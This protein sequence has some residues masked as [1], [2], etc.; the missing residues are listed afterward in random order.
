MVDLDPLFNPETIAF[1]GASENSGYFTSVLQNIRETGGD[2]RT[3]FVNPNR[4]SVLG[5]DC[6]DAVHDV[7]EQIDLAYLLVPAEIVPA[8]FQ[9]CCEAS[10]GACVIASAGFAE[11]SA[12]GSELQDTLVELSTTYSVPFCGPNTFGLVSTDGFPGLVIP[13]PD[14]PE[15]TVACVTQSGGLL[16][17][18]LYCG[19][20][21]DFGFAKVVDSGNQASLSEADYIEHFLNDDRTELVVGLIESF[22][23][24]ERFLEL[25]A[26]ARSRNI[27]VVVHKLARSD[28]AKPIARSHSGSNPSPFDE[29]SAALERHGV[30]QTAS[31]DE[32][33]ETIELFTSATAELTNETVALIEIS[34]G[35]C[36]SYVDAIAESQLELAEFSDELNAELRQYIPD[37]IGR[38]GN[39]IDLGGI[40]GW[41][42]EVMADIYPSILELLD[43]RSEAG[44][45]VAR[46]NPPESGGG[47]GKI[48]RVEETALRA[49][50]SEKQFV[51][52]S[53]TSRCAS[54]EWIEAVHSRGLPFVQGYLKTIRAIDN[55]RSYYQHPDAAAPESVPE[56][57]D[58]DD[59]GWTR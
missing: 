20:A 5:S 56:G 28:E 12:D 58:Q 16:M 6:F 30:V 52:G 8:V 34:G 45:V 29:V 32:L 59:I 54:S 21:R 43:E 42:G 53:R 47:D 9:D 25:C 14:L 40:G 55:Y 26:E 22:A 4:D 50:T 7:P 46:I 49:E 11:T 23:E 18:L 44:T 38:A 24:P 19:L 13:L 31:L 3:F 36:S 37:Y 10:V 48:E 33:I 2:I 17:E 57:G 35:G 15:G 27:P 51:I 41:Q 39:P 1:V